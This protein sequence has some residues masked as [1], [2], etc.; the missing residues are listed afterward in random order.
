MPPRA[1]TKS[2]APKKRFWSRSFQYALIGAFLLAPLLALLVQFLRVPDEEPAPVG[3]VRPRVLSPF[4]AGLLA[5]P[6]ASEFEFSLDEV[7]LH[8]GQLLASLRK[9]PSAN[10]IQSLELRLEQGG[11]TVATTYRWRG[12]DW[13]ARLHYKVSIESGRLHI[14]AETGSLG[15]VPLGARWT[16]LLQSPLLKLLPLL[17]K[18][19]I[20]LNRLE[21]IR[22]EPNRV[23]LKVRPSSSMQSP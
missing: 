18:E 13:H 2:A 12:A 22:L 23:L 20:L 5:N 17:K 14:K 19:T 8:L 21:H 4:I 3:S 1:P 15:R 7:N 11:C 9:N 6:K 10:T 16:N